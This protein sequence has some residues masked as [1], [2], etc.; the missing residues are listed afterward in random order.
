MTWHP[1]Q[2]HRNHKMVRQL[3][4]EHV[5]PPPAP[6][7][8]VDLGNLVVRSRAPQTAAG[9]AG[10]TPDLARSAAPIEVGV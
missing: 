5:P 3:R 2:R 7:A 6:P 10:D 1:I 4:A 8:P 9:R